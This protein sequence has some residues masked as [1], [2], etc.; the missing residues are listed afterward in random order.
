MLNPANC[1]RHRQHIRYPHYITDTHPN[2]VGVTAAVA[3]VKKI[4]ASEKGLRCER[5]AR[6]NRTRNDHQRSQQI[7]FLAPSR[8]SS[9]R[10]FSIQEHQAL[11]E[12]AAPPS[13]DPRVRA[14]EGRLIE[15]LR[16][17]GMPEG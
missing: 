10:G 16:K 1:S 6:P 14:T 12:G 17:A 2:G 3:L 8:D 13:A 11:K 4:I 5:R 9:E 7:H 15:G